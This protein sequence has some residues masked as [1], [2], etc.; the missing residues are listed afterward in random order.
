M[1]ISSALLSDIESALGDG[2]SERRTGILLS[3]SDLFLGCAAEYTEQQTT[4]FGSV[5]CQL[6]KCVENRALVELSS[7]LAPISTAPTDVIQ[8]LARNDLIEISGPVLGRSALLTDDDLANIAETKSQA[9]LSS[10]AGRSQIGEIVTNVLVDR[11]NFQVVNKVAKNEGAR[12]SKIGINTL[13]MR[14]DGNDQLTESIAKRADIPPRLFRQLLAQATDAVRETL[15]AT[16]RQ[17][18]RA[19]LTQIFDEISAQVEKRELDPRDYAKARRVIQ[20]F[21]HDTPRVKSAIAEF[22]NAKLVAEMI[23]A[24]SLVSNLPI[25]QVDRMFTA[26][27]GYGLMV[28]CKAIGLNWTITK[29]VILNRLVDWTDARFT[30]DELREQ[31]NNLPTTSAQRLL[32]GWDELQKDENPPMEISN[33]H[34]ID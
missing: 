29:S 9:H 16:A 26:P 2:S 25:M 19:V 28:L 14:A 6:M 10:I 27:S 31:F 32:R 1:L 21:G 33:I 24:L 4:M 7:R 13:V 30:L 23:A 15:L 22:A 8:A 17:N 18:Q 34:Y 5:M 20:A 3:V 12:F 11:G